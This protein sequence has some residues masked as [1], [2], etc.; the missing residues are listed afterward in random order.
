MLPAIERSRRKRLQ[1]FNNTIGINGHQDRLAR[2][3]MQYLMNLDRHPTL[4]DTLSISVLGSHASL[5]CIKLR[6]RRA[7]KET[8]VDYLIARDPIVL[9]TTVG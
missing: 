7:L 6:K 3:K 4:A 1:P 8:Y 2:K 5:F 9:A